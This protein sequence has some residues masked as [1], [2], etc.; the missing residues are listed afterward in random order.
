[1]DYLTDEILIQAIERQESDMF[2]SHDM[3]FTLMTYW[4]EAYVRELY[5]ALE[6][7]SDPFEKLH[8][9]IAKRMASRHLNHV[10]VK[11][12]GKQRSPNCRGKEDECQIWRRTHTI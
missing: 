12:D 2:D 8:T 10:V 11:H 4:A 9:D 6:S 3:Y 7:H 5:K 1:M